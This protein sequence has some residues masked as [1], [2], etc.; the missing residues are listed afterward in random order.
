MYGGQ[1]P[2]NSCVHWLWFYPPFCGISQE[3]CSAM[4]GSCKLRNLGCVEV[5]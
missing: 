5:L 1:K 3:L 4:D 2:S